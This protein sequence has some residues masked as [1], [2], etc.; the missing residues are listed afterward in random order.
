M[1]P[2]IKTYSITPN[3]K[4]VGRT[5]EKKIIEDFCHLKEA[6]ILVVYGRRRIGKTELLEQTLI[7]KKILKF[8]G[9]EG[10]TPQESKIHFTKTLLKYTPDLPSNLI[11]NDSWLDLFECLAELCAKDEWYIY[12][13]EIQWLASYQEDFIAE[14]KHA[15]DNSFK[16]NKQLKLILCGSSPSFIINK[17]IRSRSLY[18][19]SMHSIHVKELSI[20]ETQE[21]IGTKDKNKFE[22]MDAYL[23][24]GGIPEYLKVLK[25][26]SSYFL[27]IC[28]ESFT[29]NGYFF[30]E[31]EKIFSSTL[32]YHPI[33]KEIIQILGQTHTLSR[34]ALI[35]KL[36]K[37]SGGHITKALFE[38]EETGLISKITPIGSGPKTT[39]VVYTLKDNYLHF[40]FKFIEPIKE[41]IL[42]GQYIDEPTQAISYESYRK[43]LGLSFERYCRNHAHIFA[44]IMSFAAVEYQSGYL[45]DRN[46]IHSGKGGVQLDLVFK[47][48]DRV[49]SLCEIKY[50]ENPVG[51]SIMAEMN[52]KI[53]RITI[54]NSHSISRVLISANGAQ[55]KVIDGPNFDHIITLNDI[56]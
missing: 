17:I 29:P 53:E 21:L 27:D 4:F 33:H 28:F 30:N 47:R 52:Q 5:Q 35:K 9:I 24:L 12:F 51:I 15:W 39:L 48:K 7:D 55:Q 19:R 56:F 18:N 3:K 22:I 32:S 16:R 37:N 41:K 23:T 11:K 13:E 2:K 20:N 44:K 25:K 36:K 1:I 49:L 40:Y 6:A 42:R 45:F 31:F 50:T 46:G 26:R 14:L 34:N 43:W 38:L 10:Q 54:P 8:E